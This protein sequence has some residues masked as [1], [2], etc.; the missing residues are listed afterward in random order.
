MAKTRSSAKGAPSPDKAPVKVKAS[1]S[2]T[3]RKATAKKT[4]QINSN[5]SLKSILADVFGCS[6]WAFVSSVFLPAAHAVLQQAKLKSGE[7]YIVTAFIVV[8]LALLG[9]L[10]ERIFSVSPMLNPAVTLAV[11]FINRGDLGLNL[12]RIVAQFIGLS[13]GSFAALRFVPAQL[14]YGFV[15]LAGKVKD[16]LSWQVG[17]ACEA[18]L[19]AIITILTLYSIEHS[20]KGQK[21]S[22]FSL[23]IP[24]LVTIFIC[25]VGARFTGPSLNPFLAS[26][27]NFLSPS[28][29]WQENLIVF[30]AGP[31]AGAL[32]TALIWSIVM[33]SPRKKQGKRAKKD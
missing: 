5:L 24:H 18:G 33:K 9:P 16:G 27:W 31:F 4:K 30:W 6:L 2:Q 21:S 10:V 29:T 20:G 28:H 12:L 11:T 1:A 17:F 8:G 23:F 25:L 26:V 19:V 7:L 22:L 15:F 13:G 3:P 14:Q 32:V